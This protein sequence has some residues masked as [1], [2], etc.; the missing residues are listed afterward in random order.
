MQKEEEIRQKLKPILD[1]HPYITI[2]FDQEGFRAVM[3]NFRPNLL[4]NFAGGDMA[5]IANAAAGLLCVVEN[6][7]AETASINIECLERADGNQLLARAQIVKLGKR[8]IR[9]RVD[10]N[11]RK[12]QQE[13]LVAIAQI[14]MSPIN[15]LDIERLIA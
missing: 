7:L 14:N 10:V 13:K 15:N 8:L 5:Y 2:E 1:H 9:L 11:V 6:R 12:Q 3:D 4:G